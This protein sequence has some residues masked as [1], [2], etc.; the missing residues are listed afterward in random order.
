MVLYHVTVTLN[1]TP[2]TIYAILCLFSLH[3]TYKPSFTVIPISSNGK[4]HFSIF[5]KSD[6][7]PDFNQCVCNPNFHLHA[8]YLYTRFHWKW[9]LLVIQQKDFFFQASYL[10]TKV[11]C[12]M[13]FLT[14]YS[15]TFSI[16]NNKELDH[17]P[18]ITY[19]IQ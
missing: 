14:S 19:S 15:G 1:L 12:H 2:V 18:V 4:N 16:L 5:S 8:S 17:D 7:D 10:Y 3:A 9:L 6:F 13:P 11:H